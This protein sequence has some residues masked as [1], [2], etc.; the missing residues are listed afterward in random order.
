M[1]EKTAESLRVRQASVV[2]EG[3]EGLSL[4]MLYHTKHLQEENKSNCFLRWVTNS[5]EAA[6]AKVTLAAEHIQFIIICIV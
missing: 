4:Y 2:H 1:N 5:S 3:L 6:A